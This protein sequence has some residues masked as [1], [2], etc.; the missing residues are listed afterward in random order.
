MVLDI[1]CH[2]MLA[3]ASLPDTARTAA[4]NSGALLAFVTASCICISWADN[5]SSIP[6]SCARDSF[7]SGGEGGPTGNLTTD[8]LQ[9]PED[10]RP[11]NARL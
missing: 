6:E 11:I 5:S 7:N 4:A 9:L 1:A 3:F 10:D 8:I 2:P